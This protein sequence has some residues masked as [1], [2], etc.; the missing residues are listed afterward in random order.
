[1][2]KGRE[3]LHYLRPDGGWFIN[4]DTFEGIQFIDCEPITKKEFDETFAEY[5]NL[6]A[7]KEA[8][9]ESKKAAAKTKLTSLGLDL[10]D[11]KALGL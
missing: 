10:D 2:P 7:E 11:L 3:V 5:D 1:M 4:G 8:D 6:I 9:L